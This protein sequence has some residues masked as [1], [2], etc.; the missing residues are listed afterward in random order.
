MKNLAIWAKIPSGCFKQES[1][2]D[3]LRCAAK[4]F[5]DAPAIAARG[6]LLRWTILYEVGGASRKIDNRFFQKLF[7]QSQRLDPAWS[8]VQKHRAPKIFC[9]CIREIPF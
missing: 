7:Q 8:C 1:H 5:R 6:G 3:P 4:T 2:R 9:D